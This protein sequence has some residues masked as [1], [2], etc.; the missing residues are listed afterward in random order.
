MTTELLPALANG[1]KQLE[2]IKTAVAAGNFTSL[3]DLLIHQTVFLHQLGMD[4]IERSK[5]E[6]RSVTITKYVD[7]GLRALSQS[8]KAMHHLKQLQPPSNVE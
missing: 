7:T 4:L 3:Q 5:K 6:V 1:S 8:Q 2:Q